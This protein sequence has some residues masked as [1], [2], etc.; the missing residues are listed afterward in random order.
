MTMRGVSEWLNSCAGCEISILDLGEKMLD[1]MD[2][3][4]FIHFPAIMDHKYYGQTGQEKK[5]RIPKADIG[6]ISGG[7]R[8]REQLA[9]ALEM[10]K[11]CNRIL[12]LGTCATHGGIPALGNAYSTESMTQCYYSTRTT[13][14]PDTLPSDQLPELLDACYALDEKIDIDLFLPG[15]P[16]HPDQIFE[17]VESLTQHRPPELTT[18]SVCDTCPTKRNGKGKIKK[19]NRFLQ[20]LSAKQQQEPLDALDCFLEQ[21]L[22]CMGPV[23]KAGCG[24]KSITPRCL[25]ARVPCRGCYGPVKQDGNPKLD[26]LNA[27]ASN[28]ISIDSLV[29]H[30]SLLRFSGA[31][32]KLKPETER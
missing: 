26:I 7:I 29:E 19:I 28:G 2:L 13:A 20:P 5:I 10:R 14:A 25:S 21:G 15:C 24:G 12:A 18:K 8:N 16:P 23:T 22:L 6:I 1:L 4:D 32:G 9:I 3:V 27:L 30:T 11:K 31:H 17:A